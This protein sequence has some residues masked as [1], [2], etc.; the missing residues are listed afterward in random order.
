MSQLFFYSLWT[1]NIWDL[2]FIIQIL[3]F[4]EII[5][6]IVLLF[7][8]FLYKSYF[9]ISSRDKVIDFKLFPNML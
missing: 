5:F 4:Y 3:Y 9:S 1:V 6:K 2:I 8:R 7:E